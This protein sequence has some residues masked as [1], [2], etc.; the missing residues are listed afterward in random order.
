MGARA[1]ASEEIQEDSPRITSQG[2]VACALRPAPPRP[3]PPRPAP[4][5]P[6][7]PRESG[8]YHA[9]VRYGI[10]N[11][12]TLPSDQALLTVAVPS[13]INR[14]RTATGVR[15]QST[16]NMKT[17]P[18]L[19]TLASS[20]F[21]AFLVS[22]RAP[23]TQVGPKC[24]AGADDPIVNPC[25]D[26]GCIAGYGLGFN[27]WSLPNCAGCKTTWSWTTTKNGADWSHASGGDTLECD[28]SVDHIIRCPCSGSSWVTFTFYCE[29]CQ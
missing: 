1:L 6:A 13:Q 4:P 18:I 9:R 21:L 27:Y 17:L 8:C 28:S 10:G 24:L 23:V 16:E 3:A 20:I 29:S 7:P 14:K 2:N 19:F 25:S 12:W 26:T 22:A 15:S 5:R 11:A